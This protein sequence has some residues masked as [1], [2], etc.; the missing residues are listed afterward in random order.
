NLSRNDFENWI[1][2]ELSLKTENE[3]Y[4]YEQ[5]KG[6]TFTLYELKEFITKFQD[7][8]NSKKNGCKV[9]KFEFSSSEA[10][11]DIILKDPLE[12]NLITIEIWINIGSIT[13]GKF[14][15]YDKGFRFDVSLN[16][17]ELFT[18]SIKEQFEQLKIS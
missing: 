1:P 16:G 10:Y 6:A 8:I 4:H 18:S 11:F 17:F 14:F 9:Y 7:I 2:F 3:E 12:E 13:N 5:E 15:G